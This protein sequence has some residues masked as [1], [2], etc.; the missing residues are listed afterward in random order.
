[1]NVQIKKLK[2][3]K[4]VTL[5]LAFV[6]GALGLSGCAANSAKLHMGEGKN[7]VAGDTT[8][9]NDEFKKDGFVLIRPGNSDTFDSLAAQYLGDENR[10]WILAKF[11]RQNKVYPGKPLVVPLKPIYLGGL[12]EDSYQKV[13]VLVYHQF[14]ADHSDKL[15]VETQKFYEQ[16]LY[17]KENG[18]TTIGLDQLLDFMEFKSP[19]P[20]KAVVI[21][22]DDGW[23]SAFEIAYPILKKF[24][25]SATLFVY[26]DFIE[27]DR[28][29]KWWQ[30]KEMVA[31][32]FDVQSHTHSY[33][34][35]T[36]INDTKPFRDYFDFLVQDIEK[37]RMAIKDNLNINCRYLAYP[38]GETNPLVISLVKKLGYRAAFTASRGGTPFFENPYTIGRSIIHGDFDLNEFKSK[39][40]Y[41]ENITLK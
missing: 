29:M 17:L 33:Q 31:N 9:L 18:Y 1:M 8:I 14:S 16:M 37:S 34:S 22:I 10:G 41:K 28:A 40:S 32:G 12:A 25:F 2:N 39:V 24:G 35:L 3:R 27:K 30:L 5:I 11:N 15:T 26:T 7:S 4:L 38:Y 21:T 36:M 6:I 13:P 19:L 23:S 20:E